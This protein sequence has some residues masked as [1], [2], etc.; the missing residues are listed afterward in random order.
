MASTDR[1]ADVTIDDL[2]E[3]RFSPEVDE[4]RDAMGAMADGLSLEPES[5]LAAATTETGLSDFGDDA[6][7]ERLDVLLRGPARRGRALARSAC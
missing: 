5:L 6:F 1:P 4:I 3:P 7:R 2:A